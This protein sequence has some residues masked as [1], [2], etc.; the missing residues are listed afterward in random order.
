MLQTDDGSSDS[1]GKYSLKTPPFAPLTRHPERENTEE[2]RVRRK[3]LEDMDKKG[4]TT[5][6]RAE[7]LSSGEATDV[8]VCQIL[9]AQIQAEAIGPILSSNTPPKSPWISIT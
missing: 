3:V 7:V 1:S 2:S 8:R 9:T 4:E 6:A 5:T